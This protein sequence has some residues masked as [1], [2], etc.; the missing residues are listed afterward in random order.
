[1]QND[2]S[3]YRF[4]LDPISKDKM[5]ES[6]FI[7]HCFFLVLY[8]VLLHRVQDT[9]YSLLDYYG[10]LALADIK[11]LQHPYLFDPTHYYCM[12]TGLPKHVY[13]SKLSIHRDTY[14]RFLKEHLIPVF[15]HF[16]ITHHLCGISFLQNDPPTPER[17]IITLF[18][19]PH[20][21]QNSSD[22]A[23]NLCNKL[24]AELN[25]LYKEYLLPENSKY[26]NAMALSRAATA[27]SDS[28]SIY[29]NACDLIA[30]S[31][32]DYRP[33]LF[34]NESLPEERYLFSQEDILFITDKI[35]L[36]LFR[37]ERYEMIEYLNLLF[38]RLKTC[39]DLTITQNTLD[40]LKNIDLAFCTIY[41]KADQSSECYNARAHLNIDCCKNAV[42]V[43]LL[44]FCD[45]VASQDHPISRIVRNT[46]CYIHAKYQEPLTLNSI[47]QALYVSPAHL[48]R[49]FN[50]DMKMSIH[51]YISIVRID[52]AKHLLT[53]TRM[54]IG[55]IATLIGLNAPLHFTRLFKQ[56]TGLTPSIYREQRR[57]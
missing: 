56:Y 39:F 33:R 11:D 49:V 9:D 50:R 13:T 18:S 42:M 5:S 8:D 47:A 25:Q 19:L 55:K 14:I 40:T 48:S 53:E 7:S 46:V 27:L 1:V 26:I 17:Y 35:K 4:L 15:N 43:H 24:N 34:T 21:Q 32:F 52:R 30:C 16:F 38:D 54:P 57:T 51:Q 20:S 10:D 23:E 12:I 44:D 41:N 6:S 45:Y 29:R 36:A 37:G 2:Y 22:A 31:F 28:A 3:A